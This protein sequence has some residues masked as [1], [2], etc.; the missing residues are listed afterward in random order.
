[1]E[2]QV[3]SKNLAI[4]ASGTILFCLL[5]GIGFG[6]S[7]HPHTHHY[8][9]DLRSRLDKN[10]DIEN[11]RL[12]QLREFR[13]KEHSVHRCCLMNRESR[14]FLADIYLNSEQF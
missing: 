4:V 2:S 10:F 13:A 1:M 5:G 3:K 12:K 8:R 14:F 7:P 6:L 11:E 9:D